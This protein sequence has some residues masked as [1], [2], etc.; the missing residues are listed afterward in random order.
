MPP[1][2]PQ[3]MSHHLYHQDIDDNYEDEAWM[4]PGD[5][6]EGEEDEMEIFPQ[7]QD[8]FLDD[9]YADFI[10]WLYRMLSF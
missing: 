1:F 10:A 9:L 5:R 7:D 6:D 8:R 4:V 3:E 2:W